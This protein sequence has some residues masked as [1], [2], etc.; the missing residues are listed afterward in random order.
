MPLVRR[1][2]KR[3]FTN[4]FRVSYQVVH[5]GDLRSPV[6]RRE[7]VTVAALKEK[8]LAVAAPGRSR[9]WPTAS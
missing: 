3:G 9:C 6:R 2:P 8:G 5:L 7:T 1:I 4:I